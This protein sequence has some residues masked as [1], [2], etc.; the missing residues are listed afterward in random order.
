MNLQISVKILNK[1]IAAVHRLEISN[2]H[3]RYFVKILTANAQNSRNQSS[4]C[5]TCSSSQHVSTFSFL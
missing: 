1:K 5:N 2:L 4:N 3:M